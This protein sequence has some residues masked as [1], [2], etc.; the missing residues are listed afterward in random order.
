MCVDINETESIASGDERKASLRTNDLCFALPAI[1][2]IL[3]E[4]YEALVSTLMQVPSLV[5]YLELCLHYSDST[6]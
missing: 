1:V 2:L 3:T 4:T 5:F 6:E